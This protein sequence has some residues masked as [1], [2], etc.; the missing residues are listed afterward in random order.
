MDLKHKLDEQC[1]FEHHHYLRCLLLL[2]L[3][4]QQAL[5]IFFANF[6]ATEL[7]ICRR[8]NIICLNTYK[9]NH[10]WIAVDRFHVLLVNQFKCVV[11]VFWIA[12]TRDIICWVLCCLRYVLL[13]RKQPLYVCST[14]V[15]ERRICMRNLFACMNICKHTHTHILTAGERLYMF[16]IHPWRLLEYSAEKGQHHFRCLLLVVLLGQKQATVIRFANLMRTSFVS[17]GKLIS[18]AWTHA[19]KY[20]NCR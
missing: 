17:A 11:V 6:D 8:P 13:N 12:C 5:L 19:N 10:I 9:H 2:V 20:V 7:C 16:W 18:Y 4:E 3:V 15:Q 1:R 14:Y